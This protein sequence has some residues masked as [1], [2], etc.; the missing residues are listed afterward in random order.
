MV[1]EIIESGK[2]MT[3]VYFRCTENGC[4]AIK[5]NEPERNVLIWDDL[6]SKL[7]SLY[8]RTKETPVL[9]H[10]EVDGDE[11]L[12]MDIDGNELWRLS[13]EEFVEI[14]KSPED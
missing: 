11:V 8:Q 2:R 5:W 4:Q 12:A 10:W 9:D 14:I 3:R 1:T 13:Q 6:P 7:P